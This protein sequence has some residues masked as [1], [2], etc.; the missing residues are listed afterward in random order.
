MRSWRPWKQQLSPMPWYLSLSV[1]ESIDV[2][3]L[4]HFRGELLDGNPTG[5]DLVPHEIF[6]KGCLLWCR[7]GDRPDTDIGAS[8]RKIHINMGYR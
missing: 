3:Q 6:V 8:P 7:I 5:I 2:L 4:G 1:G